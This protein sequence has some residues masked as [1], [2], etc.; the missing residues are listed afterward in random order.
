MALVNV[1]VQFKQDPEAEN[2]LKALKDAGYMLTGLRIE[3][4]IRLEG[5]ADT[6]KL[7]PMF[8][9]PLYQ[10][11]S[12]KSALSETDGPIIEIGYQ[13]AVTD[14]ET[15]SVFDGAR[16]L[17]VD[18]LEWA[19]LSSRYQFTGATQAEAERIVKENLFNSIV[20]TIITSEHPWDSLRPHGV[21]DGVKQFPMSGLSDAELMKLSNENSW[22]A[23]LSQL[24]ALQEY[25]KKIGRPLTDA[26]IEITVQSWSDHCYHTTWR[27][28]KLMDRL[29]AATAKINHPAVVSVFKD[30]A[31]GMKFYEDQV[32]LIKGETHNFPSA[33]ATFGGVATKH[34]GV[35]RDAI[36]FGRGGYA[37]GGST[38]MGTMD[39]RTPAADVPSGA[40]HPRSI[41]KESIRATGYYCNPMGIP[42]MYPAFRIHPGFPKCM[43]LGHTM[44][45]IP[46][47]YALKLD[48]IPGDAVV[49][50][51]GRTGRDGIHGATASSAAMTDESVTKDAAAVQIGLPI[52]ERKFMTAVP[53]LRDKECL[54]SITDLGAGG[55][56]CA[57][58]EMGSETGVRLDLSTVLLKDESLAPW[59][60]LL[61]ESQER[62]CAAVPQE[63]LAEAEE[64]LRRYDIE[65]SIIGVFTDNHK[66][67][68]YHGD[69]LVADMDMPFIW[70]ACPIEQIE[71]KE[72]AKIDRQVVRA[73]P[74]TPAE[75]KDAVEKVLTHFHCCDQ[76]AAGT[77]FDSTV[78]GRT[79]MGPYG[80]KNGRMRNDAYISA[81]IRGKAY[82]A[83]ATFANNV[84]YGDLDPA[85]MA[86]LSVIEAIAKAVAVGVSMDDIVLCDNFY[87]PK[88]RPEVAWN[89]RAMV[90]TISDLSET[91]GAPFISGKDSS[92]GTFKS[93]TGEIIDVP[94][95]LVVST[96]GRMQDVCKAV[97]KEFKK[98]GNRLIL[99]GKFDASK[100]GGS[101]YLDAYGERGDK[102]HDWGNMWAKDLAVMYRRLNGLY[103][104]ENPIKSASAIAEGGLMLRLF[105]ASI[106]SGLGALVDL[107]AFPDEGRKDG[108]LFAEAVGSILVEL[109]S[110]EDP[111][112]HFGGL[113]WLEIGRVIGVPEIEIKDKGM[114]VLQLPI[115]DLVKVWEKPFAE[116]IR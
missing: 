112:K 7:L 60:I 14:P 12:Y 97:S 6:E 64:I 42:M 111:A 61:S 50:F 80:G 56:S 59:E 45:I 51:G 104:N 70:K 5:S 23:P 62:M 26:E 32:I 33:I 103:W 40:L 75:W 24:K 11:S 37:I 100:L 28:L 113:P 107:S 19:R 91:F 22:Y 31:G 13:R 36:G 72:P 8:V 57:A 101:V 47:K 89:L 1:Y 109:D 71:V 81:P 79:V 34:G 3:R 114:E 54:R 17:G 78:Q 90:E 94:Y 10:T 58:G 25:E 55:I 92:S 48:V 108:N 30:N 43:A 77:Q 83:V 116:V 87:T 98:V 69:T 49:L 66:L 84:F 115:A 106:G 95:T 16:A 93:D 86:R 105:E 4:V 41:V 44:G 88:I 67:T 52:T 73:V 35:I 15:P 21:P 53:E 110:F 65:Y 68:A 29:Q 63:K 38:I 18:G 76:S 99:L 82:G 39:P 9:N 20:Q 27:S 74:S 102:L 85:G 2:L 96:T 46:E